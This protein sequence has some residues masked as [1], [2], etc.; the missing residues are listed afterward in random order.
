MSKLSKNVKYSLSL[1][2]IIII[3]NSICGCIE[4]KNI[5]PE[6]S[7]NAQP[8]EGEIPLK[9]NFKAE[10]NDAD[11]E[12][13]SYYWNFGDGNTSTLQNPSHTYQKYG[14]MNVICEVIDN[15]GDLNSDE[16]I[17][18]INE[19]YNQDDE[20]YNWLDL[21]LSNTL[22]ILL[23][24]S[25]S[26]EKSDS[27][28]EYLEDA[29]KIFQDSNEEIKQFTI[30]TKDYNELKNETEKLIDYT[31]ESISYRVLQIYEYLKYPLYDEDLYYEYE[32]NFKSAIESTNIQL[33][34]VVDLFI[35]IA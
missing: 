16:I 32:D 2:S 25:T 14:T 34:V 29:K 30:L 5:P 10:A 21:F 35:K 22:N 24:I 6:I 7:I 13:I 19:P 23:N 31:L 4:E 26:T 11:G 3:F 20:L 1:I 27:Y 17:I 12:V 33:D 18:K 15:K 8:L 9:V 28:L